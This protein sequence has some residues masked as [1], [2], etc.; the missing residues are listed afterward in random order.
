MHILN[1]LKLQQV[2]TYQNHNFSLEFEKKSGTEEAQSST[3]KTPIWNIMY[4][5]QIHPK[6]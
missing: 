4:V 2:S 1:D 6:I 3:K 5:C